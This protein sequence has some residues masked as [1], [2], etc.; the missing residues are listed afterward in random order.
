ML[1]EVA[2]FRGMQAQKCQQWSEA[3]K[4]LRSALSALEGRSAPDQ[5]AAI[6]EGL[7]LAAEGRDD[8][9]GAE[10]YLDRF[11]STMRSVGHLRESARGLQRLGGIQEERG[12]LEEAGASYEEAWVIYQDL[13]LSDEE[14]AR[15]IV[16]LIEG[17][18]G[19]DEVGR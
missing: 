9:P 17:L 7:A 2:F 11:V 19:H 14:E 16:R 6:F 12:N 5:V 4:Y 15:E 10:Q 18:G 3:E 1:G 13:D 8:L